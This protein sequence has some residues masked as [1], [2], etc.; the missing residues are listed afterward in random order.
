[1]RSIKQITLQGLI[2]AL[3]LILTFSSSLPEQLTN[4]SLFILWF[5]HLALIVSIL[6]I[7]MRCG[8]NELLAIKRNGKKLAVRIVEKIEN[9]PIVIRWTS[10]AMEVASVLLVVSSG[11]LFLGMVMVTSILI[12]NGIKE[13]ARKHVSE[14]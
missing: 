7:S 3:A 1:M 14:N 12:C 4:I 13:L 5:I 8:V 10:V 6:A 2:L 9:T 11:W